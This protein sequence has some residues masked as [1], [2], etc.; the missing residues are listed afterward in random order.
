M[1]PYDASGPLHVRILQNDGTNPPPWAST[2]VQGFVPP[3]WSI[4]S[5]RGPS[6]LCPYLASRWPG[7]YF[8]HHTVFFFAD[9]W[10]IY[11]SSSW[12]RYKQ[13]ALWVFLFSQLCRDQLKV[14]FGGIGHWLGAAHHVLVISKGLQSVDDRQHSLVT[15]RRPFYVR[16][17]TGGHPAFCQ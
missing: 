7:K 6:T 2:L 9:G 15:A 8:Q 5:W 17:T 4:S 1:G 11:Q 10:T 16:Q 3:F 13:I 12:C 14:L